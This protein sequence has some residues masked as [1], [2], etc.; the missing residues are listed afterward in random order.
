MDDSKHDEE[1][2]N[3]QRGTWGAEFD[4]GLAEPGRARALGRLVEDLFKTEVLDADAAARLTGRHSTEL[5]NAT[6]LALVRDA[7]RFISYLEVA[8]VGEPHFRRPVVAGLKA[9]RDCPQPKRL[10]DI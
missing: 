8:L 9:F 5:D 6:A 2:D 3:Y 1:I 7:R 4:G 10:E